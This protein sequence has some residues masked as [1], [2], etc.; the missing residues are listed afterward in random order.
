RAPSSNFCRVPMSDSRT[1]NAR[2]WGL[3]DHS[4]PGLPVVHPCRTLFWPQRAPKGLSSPNCD[5]EFV[6]SE[7]SRSDRLEVPS[8]PRNPTSSLEGPAVRIPSELRYG[9]GQAAATDLS[10]V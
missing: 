1:G 6:G 10:S 2:S 7:L 9:N 5:T 3:I 8:P 4:C